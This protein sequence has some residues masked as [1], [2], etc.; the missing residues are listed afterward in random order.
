MDPYKVLEIERGS[1]KKQIK[2]AYRKLALETHPDQNP[3]LP[4]IEFQLVHWAYKKITDPDRAG[5]CPY[6]EPKIKDPSKKS[7]RGTTYAKRQEQRKKEK[8]KPPPPNW[9]GKDPTLK[10]YRNGPDGFYSEQR[11]YLFTEA[12]PPRPRRDRRS[13][14]NWEPPRPRRAVASVEEILDDAPQSEWQ[15]K[16]AEKMNRRRN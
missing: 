4:E 10:Y 16:W 1:T 8:M 3:N 6:K 7:P 11:D 14:G 13:Q 15:R 5:E 9:G 12:P 2:S